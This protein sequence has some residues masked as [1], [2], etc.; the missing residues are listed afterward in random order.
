MNVP[1]VKTWSGLSP[2]CQ[3]VFKPASSNESDSRPFSFEQR[4][5]SDCCSMPDFGRAGVGRFQNV[6]YGIENCPSWIF[7]CGGQFVD[8]DLSTRAVHAVGKGSARVNCN[9]E[10]MR[11]WFHSI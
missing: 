2:D 6:T 3:R 5:R 9:G 4:I 10:S 8:L 11:H 1:V 7:R